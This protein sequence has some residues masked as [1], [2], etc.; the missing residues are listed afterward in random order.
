MKRL[1]VI[2]G[3]FAASLIGTGCVVEVESMAA[4]EENIS[5]TEDALTLEDCTYCSYCATLPSGKLYRQCLRRCE[6]KCYLKCS[7]DPYCS[8]YE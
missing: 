4:E 1:V 2:C 7:T 8:F 5:A 6:L 3:V